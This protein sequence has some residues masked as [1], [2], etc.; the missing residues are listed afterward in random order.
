VNFYHLN[1]M[2]IAAAVT[3]GVISVSAMGASPGAS[4]ARQEGIS[5]ARAKVTTVLQRYCGDAC[6][7]IN[8][9]ADVDETGSESEDLGF[10]SIS[11]EAVTNASIA[12]M[13]VDIQVDDRVTA[14]DQERL[15]RLVNNAVKSVAPVA[16]VRWT[17]VAFPQI[18][19]S[20]E[21]EDRLKAGLRQRMQAAVQQTI[22]SY[23]AQD[24]VLS[25]VGVDGK[26]VSPDEAKGV[27]ER[28]IVR[29]HSGRGIL[30]IENIDVDISIDEKI[31]E[32]SRSKIYN[33]IKARTRFA[34]PVNINVSVVD[35]PESQSSRAD[36]DP[37]GL[38]RLR[39][40]LQIFRDL[41]STKEII[42][43]T[44][45]SST[46]SNSSNLSQTSK[47]TS[48]S[49]RSESRESRENSSL[50]SKEKTSASEKAIA[51]NSS[52][53]SS[54]I[55]ASEKQQGSQNTEYMAYIAGFLI[56][57][58]IIVALIIR[59]S[60]ASKEARLMMES[61]PV[62]HSQRAPQGQQQQSQGYGQQV[63]NSAGGVHAANVVVSDAR[64]NLS[65]K[66]RIECLREEILKSFI[67]NPKVARDTFTRMLQEEGVE[68]TSRYVH[69][70]G[71]VIIFDLMNDPNLQRDLHDLSEYYYKAT[72]AFT[73]EQT[74]DLLNSLRTKVTSSEIRV[75]ARKR[76]EQFDFLQNLEATQ[77]FTL[78]AE[79]KPHV[80]SV[81]LTQL[82]HTKRRVVFDMYEG[83]S[84]VALMRELCKADA[85]PK[86]YLANVAKA[87]HKKVLSRTE[88]DTE[89]LRSSDIIIDLL[90][91]AS[92]DD[93]R[94]LMAD[95]VH[96]NPEAA[97]AIKLKLVTVEMLPYIKDGHLLEIVM[98]LDREDLLS[99][100][101]GTPDHI[102]ELLLAKAPPEL[103][104][105]WIEDV[106]Q[107]SGIDEG[108]YRMAEMRILGRVRN[109]ANSGA[110]RL[111]DINDRIFAAEHL[112][113]VRRQNSQVEMALS[114][115]SVAA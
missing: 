91:K 88:Y 56:L 63:D 50:T 80:Q 3:A 76:T 51:T 72:F 41:A 1:I 107:V 62:P 25:H 46:A 92:L 83:E 29:E 60:A 77:V 87:L 65:I 13:T 58:G 21:V 78:I 82:D 59:M 103:A 86:E 18:G 100:L 36:K 66:I 49:E 6:E 104:Q 64:G 112:A 75:M 42:T 109:L 113:H 97:R 34:F 54:E 23:C 16:N 47:E 81:V 2:S 55:S 94:A 101:I 43:N 48:A 73:D 110:I 17:T 68:Q 108:R 61:V 106:E 71:P 93:Q 44:T 111:L 96:T 38:E 84:K 79:E 19:V 39:Q 102:R 89:Q 40:T 115:N 27:P 14:A 28:E 26:L 105:S 8:I 10:E 4:H 7:L 114:R 67:D 20:A 37:W 95:L 31:P 69:L 9:D 53:K 32:A 57:A 98:G 90:E 52:E 74:L 30:R 5:Q 15:G 99:F 85:I 33:L 70:L 35:F 24:C 11:G 12:R 45:Q 22:D